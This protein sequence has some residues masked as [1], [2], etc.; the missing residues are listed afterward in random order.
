[1]VGSDGQVSRF[2]ETVRLP[3]RILRWWIGVNVVVTVSFVLL[4]AV[5]DMTGAQR[6]GTAVFL[7]LVLLWFWGGALWFVASHTVVDGGTLSRRV[8]HK[9]TRVALSDI[10]ATRVWAGKEPGYSVVELAL[11]DGGKTEITTRHRDQLMAVF[12]GSTG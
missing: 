2:S 10:A 12:R 8:G 9:R 1:M 6:V 3:R 7:L 11:R 5:A 4:W